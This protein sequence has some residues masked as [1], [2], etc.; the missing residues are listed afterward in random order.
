MARFFAVLKGGSLGI[1]KLSHVGGSTLELPKFPVS[2]LS[3][4][5]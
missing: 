2:D 4:P 5:Q 3:E 1:L